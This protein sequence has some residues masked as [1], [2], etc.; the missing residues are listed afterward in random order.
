MNSDAWPDRQ[1][2]LKSPYNHNHK[3]A[4]ANPH[5]QP[6]V[7][8]QTIQNIASQMDKPVSVGSSVMPSVENCQLLLSGMPDLQDVPSDSCSGAC[9][10]GNRELEKLLT[11]GYRPLDKQDGRW[12]EIANP[13]SDKK[14]L[15]E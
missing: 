5:L 12:S 3:A 8:P 1:P 4:I 14:L 2:T 15:L 11:S 10:G 7:S 9:P 13:H 6:D